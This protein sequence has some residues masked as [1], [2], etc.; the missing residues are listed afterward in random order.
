MHFFDFCVAATS[1]GIFP[2]DN[3][4]DATVPSGRVQSLNSNG[5]PRKTR[6]DGSIKVKKIRKGFSKEGDQLLRY[7]VSP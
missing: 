6:G 5:T 4:E 2:D 7:W 3:F 1:R